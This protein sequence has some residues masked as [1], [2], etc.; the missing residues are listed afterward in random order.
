MLTAIGALKGCWNHLGCT[1]EIGESGRFVSGSVVV[2]KLVSTG[3]LVVDV[4]ASRRC[5]G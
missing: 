2:E 4:S 3:S 1:L 5:G